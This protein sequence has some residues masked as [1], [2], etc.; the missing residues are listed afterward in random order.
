MTIFALAGA[1]VF[2]ATTFAAGFA[3]VFAAIAA[4]LTAGFAVFAGVA[5]TAV[6]A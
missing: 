3:G 2:F 4:G 1:A 5:R 6:F